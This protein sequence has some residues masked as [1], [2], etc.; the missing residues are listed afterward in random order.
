[1]HR[2]PNTKAFTLVELLVTLIVTGILLSALATLAFALSSATAIESNVALMQSQLRHGT[3]R[4]GELIRHC[5]LLCAIEG[6]ALA[7]WEADDNGDGA[8]N[9]NELVY[10]ETDTNGDGLQLCW[11]SSV[12]NPQVIFSSGSLS[13]TKAELTASHDEHYI[14]LIPDCHNVQLAFDSNPPLT[15]RLTVS[16][17]LTENDSVHPYQIDVTLCA[18]AGHLLNAAGD[19]IVSD[20]DD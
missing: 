10:L 15:Q 8:I 19:G 20:D 14:P 7:I 17:D 2:R 3:L 13:E 16:F 5:R 4:L 9:V 1:M 18:W 6:N 11:F 12:S